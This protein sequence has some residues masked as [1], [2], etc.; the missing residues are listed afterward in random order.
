MVCLDS[1]DGWRIRGGY[2]NNNQLLFDEFYS[3]S[4]LSLPLEVSVLPSSISFESDPAELLSIVQKFFFA[5]QTLTETCQIHQNIVT[6]ITEP[7][8]YRITARKRQIFAPVVL[9][10][11]DGFCCALPFMALEK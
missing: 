8:P 1:N 6:F 10:D 4:L 9:M 3:Y 11:M 7:E 5:V 2:S